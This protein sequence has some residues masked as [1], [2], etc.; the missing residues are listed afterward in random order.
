MK[1][2]FMTLIL[3]LTLVGCS[4]AVAPTPTP[5]SSLPSYASQLH[6]AVFDPPRDLADFTMA[7]TTG[8]DFTLSAYKGKIVL[9][10]FGYRACPDFCPT[11]FAN[12]KQVFAELNEPTDKVKV[13]F[14][15]VDPERDDLQNLALYTQAFDPDFMG[16]RAEGDALQRVMDEFG[17]VATRRQLG[18]SPDAYAIDHTASVYLIGPDGR[19]QVQY[20]YGTDHREIT[21][22]VDVILKS[23]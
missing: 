17:V 12:L 16:V 8:Q 22:D 1:P 9:L 5:V 7:S 19:L 15:T 18:D 23:I 10:Y 11:T 2:L 20:V 21:H 6:G 4:S 3:A 13:V 14:V